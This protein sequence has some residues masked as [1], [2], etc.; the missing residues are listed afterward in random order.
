M[1]KKRVIGKVIESFQVLF[2]H[3]NLCLQPH[4]TKY[5]AS[6]PPPINPREAKPI[7]GNFIPRAFSIKALRLIGAGLIASN[8]RRSPPFAAFVLCQCA[9]HT[10]CGFLYYNAM[11]ILKKFTSLRRYIWHTER[12]GIRQC[13]PLS[14]GKVTHL[15]PTAFA[16]QAAFLR[17]TLWKCCASCRQSGARPTSRTHTLTMGQHS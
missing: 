16:A 13:N 15:S 8:Q 4:F 11:R 9:L 12:A 10:R 14:R 3:H 17:L 5:T 2:H 1:F 7:S 6:N